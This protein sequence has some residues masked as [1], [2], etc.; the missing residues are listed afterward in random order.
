[1]GKNLITQKRGKGASVYKSH[2]FRYVGKVKHHASSKEEESDKVTGK[3]KDIVH[4]S[5]HYA[6]IA[7]VTYQGK[8][9]LEIASFGL[10]V[11]DEVSSGKNAKIKD[12][13][14][15]PL[16]SISEGSLIFNIESLPGD[17]GKFVRTS[18][19]FARVL[20]KTSDQVKVMLPSKKEHSFNPRCRATLGV[21]AG[22]GRP[23]KPILKAGL[24]SKKRAARG[25][26]YPRTSALSM[27][28]VSHPFG[29]SSSAHKG[30]P[31]IARKNAPAGA[32]AGMLRPKR[33]GRG[34][35]RKK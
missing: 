6:P 12:G 34:K 30:K 25:K 17:G 18:G 20:S 3:V 14:V 23:E 27:N 21:V 8:E 7:K 16:E 28:A 11:G 24:M 22:G 10:R 5:G 15:L 13:N 33:T 2:S 26:L 35:G 32:K 1:M 19:G 9:S 4:S 29:G 31:L